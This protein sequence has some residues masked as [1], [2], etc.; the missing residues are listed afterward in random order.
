LP[1]WRLLIAGLLT[2]SLAYALTLTNYP[3]TQEVGRLTSTHVAAAWPVA[4][5]VA[6]IFDLLRG[7]TRWRGR[8]VVLVTVAWMAALVGYQH[9]LQR[10]YVQAW[11]EQRHFWKTLTLA[12]PDV[13]PGWSVV[14]T[15]PPRD[16]TPVIFANAWSDHHAHRQIYR[17]GMAP[18]TTWFAHLGRL[19]EQVGFERSGE[20]WR[21]RPEFWGGPWVELDRTR[22]ALFEDDHGSL[23]RVEAI[24]TPAGTLRTLAPLPT[25]ARTS[26]PDTPVSRLLFPEAFR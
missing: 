11:G 26:W 1:A 12:S 8:L 25:T 14:L 10:G 6:A 20:A 15:G 21:W 16:P 5:V 24:E 23:R 18:S 19:G 2:W 3:P 9:V 7:A 13:G 17:S 22:L 4:L